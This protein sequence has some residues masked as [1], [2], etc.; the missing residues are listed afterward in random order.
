MEWQPIS[1]APFDRDLEL[2][3]LDH[4]GPHALVFPC[5]RTLH[6]WLRSEGGSSV[7]VRPTHWREWREADKP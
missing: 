6:G 3:V 4:E 1:S 2:A 7:D 5:R